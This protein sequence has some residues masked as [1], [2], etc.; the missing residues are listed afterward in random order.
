VEVA[1]EG[2]RLSQA[3]SNFGE[4]SIIERENGN[5]SST[6]SDP[7]LVT[8][9]SSSSREESPATGH[10]G[11]IGREGGTDPSPG[12]QIGAVGGTGRGTSPPSL[13]SALIAIGRYQY[14]FHSFKSHSY[15][16]RLLSFC[17]Y[18]TS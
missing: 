4:L 2:N 7:P 17:V 14:I 16:E 10:L 18:K 8:S 12:R 5:G 15:R 9:L 13:E 1:F 6:N 3:I 11:V